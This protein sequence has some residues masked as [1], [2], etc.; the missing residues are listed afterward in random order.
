MSCLHV[1]EHIGLGRYGENIDINGTKN[2]VEELQRILVK[3][4]NLF[5]LDQLVKIPFILTC[6]ESFQ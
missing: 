6:I 5:S 3:N 1:A 2:A 4:A